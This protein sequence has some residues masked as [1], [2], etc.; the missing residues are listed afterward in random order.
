MVPDRLAGA[1]ELG[2]EPIDASGGDTVAKVLD[3]TGGR[4]AQ[5]VIEAVGADQSISDAILC[6]APG[7]TISVIGVNMN[8]GFP[9]P[10]PIALMRRLTLRVTI[11]A[12]PTTWPA[13]FPLVESGKLKPEEVFTHRLGLSDAPEAY[14][15]F[16]AREDGVLKVLL[17]PTA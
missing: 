17:D 14:R 13:L 5:S 6:A 11:A 16:E 3:A 8:L 7:G 9:F 1:A 10:M 2:A 4:G 12:I 15:I